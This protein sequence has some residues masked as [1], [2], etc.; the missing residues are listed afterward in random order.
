MFRSGHMHQWIRTAPPV[1]AA[2][3][4]V[5]GGWRT[6]G[7]AWDYATGRVEVNRMTNSNPR[8]MRISRV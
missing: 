3:K 7:A 8:V 2:E 1:S 5:R 4:R 6:V